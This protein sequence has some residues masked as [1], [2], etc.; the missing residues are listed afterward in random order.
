MRV[1]AGVNRIEPA[2][3]LWVYEIERNG[4]AAGF[5]GRPQSAI[6][7]AITEFVIRKIGRR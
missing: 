5:R 7:H 3:P 2:R 4:L 1:I 6:V